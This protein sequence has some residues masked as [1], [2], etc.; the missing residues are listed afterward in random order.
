MA[1]FT[2]RRTLSRS[3]SFAR[4]ASVR[5]FWIFS[6]R[7]IQ[8][9]IAKKVKDF[10][11]SAQRTQSSQRRTQDLTPRGWL[12]TVDILHFGGI[13]PLVRTGNQNGV[14]EA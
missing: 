5:S 10:T 9:N 6:A 14:D 11:Q 3:S 2:P 8:N 7:V 12:A 1:D 13:F 4:M